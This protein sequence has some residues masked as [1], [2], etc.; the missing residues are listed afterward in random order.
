MNTTRIEEIEARIA[1]LTKEIEK[2]LESID[3]DISLEDD[4]NDKD[5]L[6]DWLDNNDYFNVEI[7]YYSRAMEYLSNND[8]SLR[9]SLELAVDMGY[10]CEN[11]SSEILASIHASNKVRQ[12]FEELNLDDS[13]E[14]LKNLREE[15]EALQEEE[16][17]IEEDSTDDN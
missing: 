5:E 15:L 10:T 7:I 6:R 4:I 1:E 9:D 2:E 16:E 8:N 12:E 14:E 17:K 3:I 11:L 13:F